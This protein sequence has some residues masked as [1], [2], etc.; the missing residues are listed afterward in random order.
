MDTT[1]P[2]GN[3]G[4]LALLSD[5]VRRRLYE[6]IARQSNSVTREEV[7]TAIGISRSLAAYHLDRLAD[8]GLLEVSFARMNGRTGPGSGRPSK[9]YAR[10]Q[11]ERAVSFPPRNYSLLAKLL[12]T[13]ADAAPSGEFR[14]ALAEAAEHE[15]NEL[16]A[17]AGNFPSA[18]AAAGFE[19]V[20]TDDD[21]IILQNCPFHSVAQE[22]TDLACNLNHAFVRGTL[23]G[24]HADPD[25]AELS[26]ATGRC[27]VVIHPA[28]PPAHPA[29][30][31]ASTA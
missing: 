22:H 24:S 20:S 15:G 30:P 27:C 28:Q 1:N 6:F 5:D 14:V 9:R 18:L 2:H 25:R 16:A 17:N 13:A 4:D 19:P 11:D 29:Q 21:D 12:A 31:P 23:E 7:S 10:S 26:P 8:A 3:L